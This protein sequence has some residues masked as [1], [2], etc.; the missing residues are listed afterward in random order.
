MSRLSGGIAIIVRNFIA[1]REH[2]LKIRFDA[3]AATLPSFKTTTVCCV[4][5]EPHLK[6]TLQDLGDILNQL[7]K[8]FAMV[9]HF[10]ASS[11][12]GGSEK[13]DR[14]GYTQKHK[15]TG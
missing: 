15:R 9:G 14:S 5:L 10:E 7:R 4:Y 13:A 8:P 1:A 11:I 2:G 12:L 3:V 6:I